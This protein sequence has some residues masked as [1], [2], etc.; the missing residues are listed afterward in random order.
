MIRLAGITKVYRIGQR[1]L[2]VLRSID[3]TIS[4]GEMVAIMGPS[5]SGKTTLLNI[6]GCLDRPTAGSY[7]LDGDE[8]SRLSSHD[9]A[10]VRGR[11]VGFVLSLIH[12]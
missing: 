5:G 7:L 4:R 9:L 11:K 8:V 1:E 2:T 10:E 12:I 6:I 3:L